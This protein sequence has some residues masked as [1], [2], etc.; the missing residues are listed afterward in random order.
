M[1][2]E[3]EELV[4]PERL[5]SAIPSRRPIHQ[6]ASGDAAEERGILRQPFSLSHINHYPFDGWRLSPDPAQYMPYEVEPEH[7]LSDLSEVEVY[8]RVLQL[9]ADRQLMPGAPDPIGEV[10]VELFSPGSEADHLRENALPE[11]GSKVHQLRQALKNE[12]ETYRELRCNRKR[13]MAQTDSEDEG[14]ASEGDATSDEE[15][16]VRRARNQRY[17]I[18]RKEEELQRALAAAGIEQKIQRELKKTQKD[19][20]RQRLLETRAERKRQWQVVE[21]E[22]TRS[23]S[24]DSGVDMDDASSL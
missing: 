1:E 12:K 8:E 9:A 14:Q 13:R 22:E 5:A 4:H 16:L 15:R 7:D 10:N 23:D 17:V 11:E 6:T 21:E 20:R 18:R 19:A 24:F 2:A 3:V